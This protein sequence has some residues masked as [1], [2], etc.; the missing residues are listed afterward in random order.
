MCMLYCPLTLIL[1]FLYAV[2]FSFSVYK[3]L[4]LFRASLENS[5]QVDDSLESIINVLFYVILFLIV[6][7]LL[8]FQVWESLLSFTTFFFG[9]SKSQLYVAPY[10]LSRRLLILVRCSTSLVLIHVWSGR[11]LDLVL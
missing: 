6:L 8:G 3:D 11:F 4:R 5:S 9:V 7:L 10:V 1:L 2:A